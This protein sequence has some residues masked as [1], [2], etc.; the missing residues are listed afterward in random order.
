MKILLLA[1]AL[2]TT[3]QN[4]DGSYTSYSDAMPPPQSPLSRSTRYAD[5]VMVGSGG[6]YQRPDPYAAV[7]EKYPI[8][9]VV[10]RNQRFTVP[11]EEEIAIDQLQTDRAKQEVDLR[12]RLLNERI[13]R[14]QFDYDKKILD[15]AEQATGLLGNLNP[16]SQDYLA[17]KA[18]FQEQFP[19]AVQNPAFNS[20]LG[21]LD[22]THSQWTNDQDV[23]KRYEMQ[24]NDME[25]ERGYRD[26]QRIQEQLAQYGPG[27]LDIYE[28]SLAEDRANNRHP[29][30]IR[31]FAN[32]SQAVA[33]EQARRIQEK[34]LTPQQEREYRFDLIKQ[35]AAIIDRRAK[36]IT[37]PG[38]DGTLEFLNS[39]L[40][41]MGVKMPAAST[42]SQSTNFSQYEGKVIRQGNQAFRVTNGVPVPIK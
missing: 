2:F 35:R 41:R 19:L 24:R 8:R 7:E 36:A 27:A 3:F 39:E 9:E 33:T 14:N 37:E 4:P 20:Q 28:K 1:T 12:S 16:Q 11:V 38:D 22:Q 34:P 13:A 40:D 17:Q 5:A 23:L 25:N 21:R 6:Q 29:D 32:A 15:Q 10:P 42:P 18:K 26:E 30:I 31:A